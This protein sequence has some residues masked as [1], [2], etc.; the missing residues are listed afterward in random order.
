MSTTARLR[1]RS[2]DSMLLLKIVSGAMIPA[3]ATIIFNLL[4][5]FV[6]TYRATQINPDL[7]AS[8]YD[9]APGL[10]IHQFSVMTG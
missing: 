8:V 4:N 6:E 1:T 3:L 5:Y 10:T 2:L 9:I 7:S